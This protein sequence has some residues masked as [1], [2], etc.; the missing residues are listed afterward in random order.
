MAEEKKP[1]DILCFF[2][3]S[4]A[5]ELL[6]CSARL[7]GRDSD[8]SR[9][10]LPA[11]G[12]NLKFRQLRSSWNPKSHQTHVP[13]SGLV[14]GEAKPGVTILGTGHWVPQ[15]THVVLLW[16]PGSFFSAV[17]SWQWWPCLLGVLTH[18]GKIG[19]GAGTQTHHEPGGIS[20]APREQHRRTAGPSSHPSPKGLGVTPW[21]LRVPDA[22]C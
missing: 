3:V 20:A 1:A 9:A 6:V 14:E 18:N 16:G 5:R 15:P 22:P 8:P 19:A 10:A 12:L 4:P 7:R 11:S 17:P 13:A 2:P 21:S